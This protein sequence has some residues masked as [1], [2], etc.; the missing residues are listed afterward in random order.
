VGT[1]G[2]GVAMK[3]QRSRAA[4][5]VAIRPPI[6]ILEE[7][8]WRVALVSERTIDPYM[9]WADLT[10]FREFQIK[11][12]HDSYVLPGILN[13]IVELRPEIDAQQAIGKLKKIDGLSVPLM[14]TKLL[15][16]GKWSRYITVRLKTGSRR[17]FG[18]TPKSL[19]HRLMKLLDADVLSRVQIGHPRG[20]ADQPA[21][22]GDESDIDLRAAETPNV[23]I[24]ILDDFC[25]FAHRAVRGPDNS[26]RIAALW[27]QTTYQDRALPW[28]LPKY[29]PY[30]RQIAANASASAN[31]LNGILNRAVQGS[32]I[33]E[34]RC[35]GA[36]FGIN[37]A[38]NGSTFQRRRAHGAAVLD[39]AAGILNPLGQ[40]DTNE[41]GIGDLDRKADAAS[42]APIV[43]V[44]MPKEQTLISTG[45][46][47]AVNAL[48]G[49]R[50]IH[51]IARRIGKKAHEA[52]N[53]AGIAINLSYGAIAGAHDGTSMFEEAMDEI[54]AADDR[55]AIVLAAGNGYGTDV[56]AERSIQRGGVGEFYCLIPPDKSFE[57][58]V[59]I[60]I[61]DREC[62]KISVTAP[63]GTMMTVDS[64]HPLEL[65]SNDFSDRRSTIAGLIF[66][67]MSSQSTKRAMALLVVSGTQLSHSY[68]FAPSGVWKIQVTHIRGATFLAEA[69]V[70]RDDQLV[71]A[72]RGQW[73][74]FVEDHASLGQDIR[75]DVGDDELRAR[76]LQRPNSYINQRNTFSSIATG[77]MVFVVGGLR[78]RDDTITE[79]SAEGS[80]A[81]KGPSFSAYSDVGKAL[82]GLHVAGTYSGVFER[83]N[84]TSV[85]APQVTRKIANWLAAGDSATAIR[86]RVAEGHIVGTVNSRR[87]LIAY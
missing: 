51:Q 55:L 28:S 57:T 66:P 2:E 6:R 24:G 5:G 69:W 30:G 11:L 23:V 13:F 15:P 86:K 1:G 9:V 4:S 78:K 46:W 21:D 79:Y 81:S 80:S 39:L 54:S 65:M 29:F 83:M 73:A 75:P 63:D 70:E 84:G 49:I 42:K 67:S 10:H 59:E 43:F 34:E 76:G 37:T 47:L 8:E 74:R 64:G 31:S 40:I 77:R 19:H 7:K 44:Q 58:S 38:P 25:P 12:A 14:Y 33:E 60:C 52:P 72:I 85:A 17:V 68:K 50:Y 22:I 18:P 71:G 27:D 3:A 32:D 48:D 41:G 82:P 45:R 35:Y 36:E 20:R 61:P 16:N 26:T 62:C 87:G 53:E 56:H